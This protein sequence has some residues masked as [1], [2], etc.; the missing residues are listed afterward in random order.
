MANTAVKYSLF[1]N[2]LW[3]HDH[4]RLIHFIH[5]SVLKVRET[6]VAEVKSGS[7]SD[8]SLRLQ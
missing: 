4:F 8:A 7:S 1:Y 6:L 2:I 3:A 5:V